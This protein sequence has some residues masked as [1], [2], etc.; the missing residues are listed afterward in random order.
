M[1]LPLTLL[2]AINLTNYASKDIHSCVYLSEGS[3]G[4]RGWAG[5]EGR[6]GVGYGRQGCGRRGREV[7]GGGVC[8]GMMGG[9][10]CGYDVRLGRG[11]GWEEC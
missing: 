10:G 5:H 1:S 3:F 9:G 2:E 6:S 7:K 11:E 4:Y 8:V